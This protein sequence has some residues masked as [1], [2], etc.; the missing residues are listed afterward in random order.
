M[1]AIQLGFGFSILS[2]RLSLACMV[3]PLFIRTTEH[4]LRACPQSYPHSAEAL[5]I[6]LHGFVLRILLPF[7]SR[8]ITAALIISIGRALAGKRIKGQVNL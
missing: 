3:L 6:S 1:F 4:A 5:N 2:G 8:G 7:A